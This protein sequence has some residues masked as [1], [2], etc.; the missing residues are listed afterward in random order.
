MVSS[1]IREFKLGAITALFR[2][3]EN[4]SIPLKRN[5]FEVGTVVQVWLPWTFMDMPVEQLE[6]EGFPF[7]VTRQVYCFKRYFVLQPSAA[8][9]RRSEQEMERYLYS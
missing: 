3:S 5:E 9:V 7:A 4:Y 8:A 6:E 1:N 2:L